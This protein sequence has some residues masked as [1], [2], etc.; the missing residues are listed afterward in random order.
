MG[1][2]L[3]NGL[4]VIINIILDVAPAWFYRK[5][6]ESVMIMANGRRLEPRATACRQIGGAPGPC[7]HH[8]EGIRCRELFIRELADRYKDHPALFVWDLWN[9]PELTCGIA[10]KPD[11]DTMVCYCGQSAKEF[12]KWLQA[13]YETI[14]RLNKRW[15][16]NYD[17]WDEI[18]LPRDPHAFNDMIDWRLFFADTLT[19]ELA[20]RAAAVKTLDPNH[21]IM[22]HTVPMPHFN[23]V[24][25]C[26]DDYSLA[27]L[28]NLFGNSV[29]SHPFAAALST[30]AAD[31]KPVINA[32]I[33]ALGGDTFTRPDIPSFTDMKRHILIPL[34]RGIT[35]F[36]FWQYRPESLG[37]EAPAWGL[38]S[39][40]GGDTEWL[41]HSAVINNAL[42]K[43]KQYLLSAH[44]LPAHIAVVNSN[45]NQILDWCV[46]NSIDLHYQSVF[47]AYMAFYRMNYNADVI[48]AAQITREYIARYKAIYYPFPYYMDEKQA[49][50]LQEWIREGGTLISEAFFGG[51]RAEDG[52]HS[53][54]L[55][56]Y[57]FDEI[58]RAE[59]SL[60][61][62]ASTFQNARGNE[63]AKRGGEG[64]GIPIL[65]ERGL[66]YTSKGDKAI[67]YY[68]CETLRANGSEIL[69]RFPDGEAAVTCSGFGKGKGILIGSLLGYI[70]SKS[71]P[72]QNARF[73]ASLA[74]IGGVSPYV[75]A[76]CPGVRADILKGDGCYIVVI[77]SEDEQISNITLRMDIHLNSKSTAVNMITDERL[78][79]RGE[80]NKPVLD[81][82][83]GPKGCEMFFISETQ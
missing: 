3:Q 75:D 83:L 45:P 48:S 6:P 53:A 52:L 16:R 20:M 63:W 25:A 1:L 10:R 77:V 11:S 40:D 36:L 13:R 70:Y 59:E 57:G 18:E 17:S 39:P 79:M 47:G 23:M 7:Y 28:C 61:F 74:E 22:A 68:F 41:G 76:G 49:R 15:N 5:Y 55:P 80:D 67:G 29:G 51:I 26:S 60:S 42:Q 81:I 69:A 64:D 37:A 44:P 62:T 72:P 54:R 27:K 43:Y 78:T 82:K 8:V 4:K 24:N 34:S 19:E 32:E 33:H 46:T 31:G 73:L 12:M 35:G 58:F 30:S 71:A 14:G 56:G 2:A 50:I 66:K 9:E 21:P 65:Y 38:A